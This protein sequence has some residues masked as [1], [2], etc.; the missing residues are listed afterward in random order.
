MTLQNRPVWLSLSPQ[1]IAS[2]QMHF[3]VHDYDTFMRKLAHF[4]RVQRVRRICNTDVGRVLVEQQIADAALR[5]WR[6]QRDLPM[7]SSSCPGASVVPTF[8]Y[9]SC[10]YRFCVFC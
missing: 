5:R 10:L 6:E 3:N 7:L 4:L 8:Q 2:L 9:S 1:S